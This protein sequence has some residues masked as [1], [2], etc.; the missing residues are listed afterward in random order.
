[1]EIIMPDNS[2][3]RKQKEKIYDSC[4]IFLLF[5]QKTEAS[6]ILKPYIGQHGKF[7]ARRFLELSDVDVCG[8]I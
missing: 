5:F 7:H 1:M 4:H 6:S 3:F 2:V 8:G